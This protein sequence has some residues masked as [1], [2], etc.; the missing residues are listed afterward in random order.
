MARRP[1]RVYVCRKPRRESGK[2]CLEN[3][4]GGSQTQTWETDF[5][6]LLVLTLRGRSA[7]KTSTGDNFPGK[8]QR[9]PRHY[10]QYWC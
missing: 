4:N 6:P 9:I 8:S 2:H 7:G 10:Y 3:L 1:E 5:L